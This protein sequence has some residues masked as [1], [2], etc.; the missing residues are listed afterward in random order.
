MA[1][2]SVGEVDECLPDGSRLSI[3]CIQFGQLFSIHYTECG[4][5]HISESCNVCIMQDGDSIYKF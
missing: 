3:V 1:D 5:V 2:N 4:G